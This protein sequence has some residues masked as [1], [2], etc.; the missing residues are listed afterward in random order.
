M[1][2][3]L[4]VL[5]TNSHM[6][7]QRL[8]GANCVSSSSFSLPSMVPLLKLFPATTAK[9]VLLTALLV[10]DRPTVCN[11][12]NNNKNNHQNTGQRHHTI[13]SYRQGHLNLT[14]FGIIPGQD[15]RNIGD[16]PSKRYLVS[17]PLKSYAKCWGVCASS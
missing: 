1:S 15:V 5:M 10:S 12:K 16:L 8:K 14:C 11:N 9:R 3:W 7:L 2:V 4:S 13:C 6:L 17:E